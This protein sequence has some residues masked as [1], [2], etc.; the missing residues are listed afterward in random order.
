MADRELKPRGLVDPTKKPTWLK[1]VKM[2]AARNTIEHMRRQQEAQEYEQLKARG[3]TVQEIVEKGKEDLGV[4]VEEDEDFAQPT[5]E[6]SE[7]AGE[8]EEVAE[9][10]KQLKAERMARTK[11]ENKLKSKEEA[12]SDPTEPD[13][14]DPTSDN[15]KEGDK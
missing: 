12:E 8:S 13:N 11:A 15:Q 9:L 3:V 4:E 10:R 2:D 7:P 5:L 6:G 14:G 1:E